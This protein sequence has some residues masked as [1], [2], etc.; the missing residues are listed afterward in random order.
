MGW[1][2]LGLS[3]ICFACYP[4]V[5][6]LEPFVVTSAPSILRLFFCSFSTIGS[7]CS[8]FNRPFK[9]L[10]CSIMRVS[11]IQ[12]TLSSPMVR[13]VIM[14]TSYSITM[15]S[16]VWILTILAKRPFITFSRNHSNLSSFMSYLSMS[17]RRIFK[18]LSKAYNGTLDGC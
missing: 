4:C 14:K 18:P 6:I 5:V 2:D 1:S 15:L 11:V 13:P 3:T 8:L 16:V 7:M 12:T 10:G 9:A 17:Q